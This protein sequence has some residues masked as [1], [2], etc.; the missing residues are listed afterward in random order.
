MVFRAIIKNIL[1]YN[2]KNDKKA[3]HYQNETQMLVSLVKK[4]TDD[5]NTDCFSFG[6]QV[7]ILVNCTVVQRQCWT[8]GGGGGY[9]IPELKL[10]DLGEQS[11]NSHM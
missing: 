6:V 3:E 9:V 10:V 2:E 11:R 7:T 1:F 5:T 8:S 4:I